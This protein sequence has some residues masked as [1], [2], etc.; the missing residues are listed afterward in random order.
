MTKFRL[1][2]TSV[3]GFPRCGSI[4]AC[5]ALRPALP[6]SNRTCGFPA[7]GS[8]ENSRLRHSQGVAQLHRSQGHPSQFHQMPVKRLPFRYAKGSL[9]PPSK[10]PVKPILDKEIDASKRLAWVTIIIIVLPTTELR[11]NFL[12][13]ARNC[14]TPLVPGCQFT[15]FVSLTCQGFLGGKNIQVTALTAFVKTAVIAEREPKEVQTGPFLFQVNNPRL[16][17][18]QLYSHPALNLLLDPLTKPLTLILR[19]DHKVIRITHH[20]SI[21]PTGWPAPPV[22]YLIEP[23]Q[24]DV[25]QQWRNHSTLRSTPA[26]VDLTPLLLALWKALLL[27]P[28]ALLGSFRWLNDRGF[29]PHADQL[30]HRPVNYPHPNTG[31]QLVPWYRVKVTLQV[32]IIYRPKPLFQVLAYRF[33]CLMAGTTRSESIRTILKVHLKDRFQYQKHRRLHH[34]VT[35]CRYAEGPQL[36]IC[37]GNIRPAN[38]QGAIGFAT[39]L[40]LYFLQKGFRASLALHYALDAHSIHACRASIGS[41]QSPCRVQHILPI[42]IPIKGIESEFRLLLGLSAQ[43]PPQSRKFLRDCDPLTQFLGR[44]FAHLI[45]RSRTNVQSALL[46]YWQIHVP[47]QAPS[48]HPV[49]GAS[50]LLWACP[51]PG[52]SL[53]VVMSSHRPLWLGPHPAGPPRFLDQSFDTRCPLSPRR[54]WQLLMPVTSLPAL[55]FA[56]PGGLADS[57]KFN[58]AESGSLA[59]RL[60][61]SPHRG[62]APDWLPR[63]ALGRLLVKQAITR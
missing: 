40:F 22:E 31:H 57:Q 1:Q 19:K 23:V 30:Q 3:S 58:E 50:P 26:G 17:T 44:R 48:L 45:L 60:A 21:G 37:F 12:H 20:A 10:M 24:V 32:S 42:Y 34:S 46:S 55:G 5:P 18:V 49:S 29:Q 56:I 62:F 14:K 16:P 59:L 25:C 28:F 51:T 7:Y 43:F 15:Q 38:R 63:P 47:G 8:P 61:S 13:H 52:R 54:A 11:F 53:P 9:A 6:S 36:P 35:D 33:Q 2:H 4:A 27:S 39:K 41:H